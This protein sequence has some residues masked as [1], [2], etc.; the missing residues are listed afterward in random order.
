[1]AGLS[2]VP[3]PRRAGDRRPSRPYEAGE[4]GLAVTPSYGD[5]SGEHYRIE[6]PDGGSEVR[7]RRRR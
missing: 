2:A 5:S 4:A 6:V 3:L 1:M 7:L